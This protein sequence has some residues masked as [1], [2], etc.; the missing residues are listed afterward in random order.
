MTLMLDL[1]PDFEHRL[2]QAAARA[3]LP[4]AEYALKKLEEGLGGNRPKALRDL[5]AAWDRED[6]TDD[7]A[8]LECRRREWEEFKA[9]LDENRSSERRLFP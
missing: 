1:S 7:P 2:M 8:E 4:P 9:A 6:A 5:F 3:G